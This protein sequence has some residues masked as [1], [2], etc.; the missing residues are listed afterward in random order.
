M[1]F[2]SNAGTLQPFHLSR[3]ISLSGV[4]PTEAMWMPYTNNP[5]SIMCDDPAAI[6]L[7]DSNALGSLTNM[8]EL[9]DDI[10]SHLSPYMACSPTSLATPKNSSSMLA[11]VHVSPLAPVA[12][13]LGMVYMTG[14]RENASDSAHISAWA[15]P[16]D[17]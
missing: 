11:T 14:T 13:S 3:F 4:M 6:P 7:K 5:F 17:R 1:I 16:A 9:T 2:R 15:I 12:M 10:M 8:M